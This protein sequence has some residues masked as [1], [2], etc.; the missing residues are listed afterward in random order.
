MSFARVA[1]AEAG[2]LQDEAPVVLGEIG[3][4]TAVVPPAGDARS[5]AVEQQE[6]FTLTGFVVAEGAAVGREFSRRVLESRF[7]RHD[8]KVSSDPP[9]AARTF[10]IT[11]MFRP[12]R[13]G[14]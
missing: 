4:H 6:W 11:G 13:G 7:R 10:P 3:E 2:E 5:G 12:P 14:A 8:E 1:H 9:H